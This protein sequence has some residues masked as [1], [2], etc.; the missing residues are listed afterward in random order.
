MSFLFS[1]VS[2]RGLTVANRIFVRKYSDIPMTLQ[3]AHAGRKASSHVPWRSGQQIPV[4]EGG[5]LAVAPS[6][7][8]HKD[9]E[10][11]HGGRKHRMR[12][13]RLQPDPPHH[14]RESI[15]LTQW[16]EDRI[17]LE[18]HKARFVIVKSVVQGVH[19]PLPVV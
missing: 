5:W 1:P 4:A 19:R 13:S 3:L 18:A 16:I 15:L 6:S 10:E 14:V 7:L 12:H 11:L 8:A 2:I 17:H 9:G